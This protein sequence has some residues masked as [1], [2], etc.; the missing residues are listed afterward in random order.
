[1]T[2]KICRCCGN[3]VEV[4]RDSSAA[5]TCCGKEMETLVPNTTDAAGEKHV[6]AVSVAD[7]KVVARVGTVTHPMLPEHFIQFIALE[8]ENGVMRKNLKPSEA[9]EAEFQLNGEK[10]VAVYE[11]CNLHGLWKTEL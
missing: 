11:F 2:F 10:P 4:F 8:T 6:P 1:M 5:M 7:G 3:L 9:P